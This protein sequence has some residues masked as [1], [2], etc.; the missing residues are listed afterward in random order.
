LLF[1]CENFYTYC[2][3]SEKCWL[4][5]CNDVAVVTREPS[6]QAGEAHGMPHT[7]DLH[8]H[9]SWTSFR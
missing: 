2:L 4:V 7:S 9:N 3:L 1:F 6:L 5:T 8:A